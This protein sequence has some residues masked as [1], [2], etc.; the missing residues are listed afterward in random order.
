[1]RI[2]AAVLALVLLN[3]SPAGAQRK[4]LSDQD[5]LVDLE[6]QWNEAFHNKDMAFLRQILADEFVATYEDGSR[7]DK[8][9]ELALT[10][11]FNQQ[12]D[13]SVQDDFTVKVFGDTAVVWFT[14]TMVG[15]KQGVPTTVVLNY[16][17]VF[18]YRDGR[19]QCVSSHSTKVTGKQ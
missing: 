1:M 8:A 15:P 9:K 3:V 2:I 19:W 13:S 6:K 10:E 5:I 4:P 12:V 11:S 7:S 18:V 17:D 16:T 14:L